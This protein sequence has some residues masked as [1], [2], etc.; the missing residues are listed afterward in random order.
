MAFILAEQR[1]K[2]VAEAF[3][4]YREYLR[5]NEASFPKSAYALAM[6]DWYWD[7]SLSGCP[8]DAWLKNLVVTETSEGPR[9]EIRAVEMTIELLGPYHDGVIEF[10]YPGVSGYQMESRGLEMGHRDWLYDEFRIDERGRLIHEI[11][12]AGPKGTA[13]WLINASDV[14][15]KWSPRTEGILHTNRAT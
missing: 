4:L 15:Y 2:D 12:W 13:R 9:Q 5:T 10:H 1:E 8:H 11:E 6:S 14:E 7:V 3:R